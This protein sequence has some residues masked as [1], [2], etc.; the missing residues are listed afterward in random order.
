MTIGA[1]GNPASLASGQPS[2]WIGWRKQRLRTAGFSPGLAHRLACD[3]QVDLHAVLELID[4]GCRPDL[5]ARIVA[6][7]ESRATQ[8]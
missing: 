6:P 4:R 2:R 5:A 3:R 8:P 1:S 7:L